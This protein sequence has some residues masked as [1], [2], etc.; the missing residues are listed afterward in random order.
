MRIP[1]NTLGTDHSLVCHTKKR[2]TYHSFMKRIH[3]SFSSRLY[4]NILGIGY[5]ESDACHKRRKWRFLKEVKK[6]F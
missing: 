1:F 6:N 4:R 2:D 5:R 3:I